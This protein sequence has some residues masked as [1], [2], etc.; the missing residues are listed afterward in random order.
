VKRQIILPL[1]KLLLA[2]LVLASG[3][4]YTFRKMTELPQVAPF[5]LS[6]TS[7]NDS[8]AIKVERK[9]QEMTPLDP[10]TWNLSL[11]VEGRAGQTL[12][13]ELVGKGDDSTNIWFPS[14][15]VPELAWVNESTFKL[16]GKDPLPDSRCDILTVTNDSAK[17]LAYF[18]V[19]GAGEQ[20]FIVDFQPK[21]TM[22]LFIQPQ[23]DKRAS[24]SWLAGGGRFV[25]GGKM[26]E[27]KN[28]IVQGLYKAPAHYRM[29]IND[30][31]LVISSQEF[32]IWSP[33]P[34]EDKNEKISSNI[35]H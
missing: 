35:T 26:Y 2:V 8:Y 1:G 33:A 28:F 15:I 22:Q 29:T 23:S 24:L 7:P 11:S 14:F 30:A 6:S 5:S 34:P 31:G 16:T 21:Q 4:I 18:T 32:P 17:V 13:D 3:A 10:W 25:D 27:G 20:F 9:K 12:N 19:N